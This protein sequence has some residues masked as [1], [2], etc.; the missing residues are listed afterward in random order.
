MRLEFRLEFRRVN[1]VSAR[2]E[3]VVNPAT[4]RQIAALVQDTD[5]AGPVP[6]IACA[7]FRSLIRSIPVSRHA[8]GSADRYLSGLTGRQC[9][10]SLVNYADVVGR[11][12]S[13]ERRVGK[14]CVSTCRSRWSPDT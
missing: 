1:V 5:I 3:N 13:E 9:S 7:E 10:V 12:R 6:H 4:Q 11:N 2:L 8:I 14:E